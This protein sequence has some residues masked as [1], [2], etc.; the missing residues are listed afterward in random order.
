MRTLADYLPT[1]HITWLEECDK[2][3]ALRNLLG[4]MGSSRA[5][6]DPAAL[7]K[8][9]LSREVMMST[10]VGYGVAVPHAR[11]PAVDDYV[12]ALGIS[13]EG[14]PYGPV[15]DDKPV[16]LIVMIAGP[17][18]SRNG[19]LKLLSTLMRFIKSEKGKILSS[20]SADEI[21][22]FAARYAMELGS[23]RAGMGT[24]SG[25]PMTP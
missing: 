2:T 18:E 21:R 13:E 10:G 16:R 19:Y 8:A 25:D 9:I 22:R 14:V 23:G 20:T 1:S 3:Q 11:I 6:K 7:E 17:E 12:L 15:I 24:A 4:L 5:V